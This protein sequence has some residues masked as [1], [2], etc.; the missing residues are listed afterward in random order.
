[1]LEGRARIWTV[2]DTP[3][4]WFAWLGILP[5][6]NRIY[7]F[8]CQQKRGSLTM[9]EVKMEP[10]T[11]TYCESDPTLMSGSHNVGQ[12]CPSRLE[13]FFSSLIIKCFIIS[14]RT[15]W[16]LMH[17]SV[18]AW[19]L[20]TSGTMWWSIYIESTNGGG[21][22]HRVYYKYPTLCH[23]NCHCVASLGGYRQD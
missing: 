15:K 3:R 18:T 9:S 20:Y 12:C 23:Y 19:Q 4:F 1:M 13:M 17:D 22:C 16:R 21:M 5:K 6:Q 7:S 14:P 2:S 8:N 11:K 10:K